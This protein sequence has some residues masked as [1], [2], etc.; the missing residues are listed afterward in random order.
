MQTGMMRIN[1]TVALVVGLLVSGCG[2]DSSSGVPIEELSADLAAS[3]CEGR[4]ECGAFSD[5]ATCMSA[6]FLH[7]PLYPLDQLIAGVATGRLEY[8]ASAAQECIDALTAPNC[9]FVGAPVDPQGACER[10]FAGTVALGADCYANQECVGEAD[11]PN[12]DIRSCVVGTCAALPAVAGEGESCNGNTCDTGLYCDSVLRCVPFLAAGQACGTGDQC[13]EGF[14]CETINVDS[15]VC[16]MIP[17]T[18][19]AC[20]FF[21]RQYGDYCGPD[22]TCQP[23][24]LVG[25]DCAGSFNACV[26]YAACVSDVCVG[27]PTVGEPC[28]PLDA[29]CMGGLSCPN[30]VCEAWPMDAVCG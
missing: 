23:K 13:V 8:D 22:D 27:R 5:H 11:C 1:T 26:S 19:E 29:P 21:C 28:Q 14:Y 10:V 20:V 25:S 24:L 7:L 4:V 2:G 3:Y 6:G 16:T 30:G 17:D 12:F 15:P 9:S 18:N